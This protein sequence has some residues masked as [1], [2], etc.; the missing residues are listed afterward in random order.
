MFIG[1]AL[2]VG[3]MVALILIERY[4]KTG[5]FLPPGNG[6]GST[7]IITDTP[8]PIETPVDTGIS[9]TI[10]KQ[11]KAGSLS[12]RSYTVNSAVKMLWNRRE[13]GLQWTSVDFVNNG[14]D[15]VYISVNTSDFP[16]A[17]LPV[18]QTLNVDLKQHGAIDKVYLRCDQGKTANV[19]LWVVK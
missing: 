18:G 4:L 1:V 2:F 17:S 7:T 16:L 15:P 19:D 8:L 11:Q 5:Y 13:G 6:D 10:Q 12:T 9:Q 14:P 3:G